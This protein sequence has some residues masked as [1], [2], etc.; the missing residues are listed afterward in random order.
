M[1]TEYSKRVQQFVKESRVGWID[2]SNLP[3]GVEDNQI[4]SR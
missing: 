1:F 2:L 4:V 3:I